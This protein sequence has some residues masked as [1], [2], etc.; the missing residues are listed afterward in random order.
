VVRLAE[1]IKQAILS[2][3][4]TCSIQREDGPVLEIAL[5]LFSFFA[6]K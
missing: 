4:A 2:R 3:T 6:E 1:I 5:E